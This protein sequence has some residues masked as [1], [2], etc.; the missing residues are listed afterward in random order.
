MFNPAFPTQKP[1]LRDK[2]CDVMVIIISMFQSAGYSTQMK[3]EAI[4]QYEYPNGKEWEL[5]FAKGLF[6][7]PRKQKF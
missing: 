1:N 5:M 7:D 2:L 4:E 6:P 3:P